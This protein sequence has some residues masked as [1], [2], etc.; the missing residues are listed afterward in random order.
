M[1]KFILK[2]LGIK[3]R[4]LE[5]NQLKREV[6]FLKSLVDVGVDVHQNSPSWAVVCLR[7]KQEYVRFYGADDNTINEIIKFLRCFNN[8]GLIDA[9]LPF[10]K[11]VEHELY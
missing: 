1:K 2:W 10:K 8:R 3:D 6:K 5:I 9:P 4:D 11:F 7:G